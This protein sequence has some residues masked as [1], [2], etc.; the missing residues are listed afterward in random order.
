MTT[1]TWI[2]GLRPD[3]DRPVPER[4]SPPDTIGSAE[5]EIGAP[6]TLWAA[7]T[8]H[9]IV[10][11][12]TK[13]FRANSVPAMV[14][15]SEREGCEASLLTVLVGLHKGVPSVPRP[16]AA[17]ENVH[18]SVRRGVA[19]HTVLQTVWAC[20]GMVQDALLAVVENAVPQNRLVDEVRRLNTAMNSYITSYAGEIIRE[21]EDEAALWRGRVPAEQL[22]IFRSL[23]AGGAPE[24][25]AEEILGVRLTDF[26]LI[27]SVGKR[28]P[29]HVP[30]K[31]SMIATF[32]DTAGDVLGAA[33]T[34]ILPQEDITEI[35]WS[36]R[37]PPPLDHSQRLR[38]LARPSWMNV[39]IGSPGRGPNG[40]LVSH[41]ACLKAGQVGKHS[42]VESFWSYAD[43]RVIALMST[44][45]DAAQM[46]TRDELAG[47]TAPDAKVATLR[48]TLRLFLRNGGSRTVTAEHL[49]IAANTVSYRVARAGELLGR[50]AGERPVDTLL[51]LDLG[52]YFPDF[53]Q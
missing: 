43:V 33:R 21:Y 35:W 24:G 16:G 23:V 27:G 7:Q 34:L 1:S 40:I 13:K 52:H 39:A 25:N 29:G 3:P 4:A 41:R 5:R 6:A 32:A 26:H 22:R 44:D 28:A 2:P 48:E 8:A 51:A 30:E 14:T 49:H 38:A 9:R 19:V 46:F 15:G 37:S 36:F 11:E 47:L 17:T 42:A 20:H 10:D 31:D 45:R 53:L 18:Q 50:S 12:V